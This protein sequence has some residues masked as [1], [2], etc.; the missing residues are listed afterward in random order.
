MDPQI[1]L[2]D[3]HPWFIAILIFY[4]DKDVFIINN[5]SGLL[6]AGK[7]GCNKGLCFLWEISFFNFG[8]IFIFDKIH[9]DGILV[10]IS[11]QT[12]RNLLFIFDIHIIDI[13]PESYQVK[14]KFSNS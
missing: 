8:E 11:I 2:M 13:L 6:F 12:V 5:P 14:F 4:R 9:I 3:N 10:L 1:E 7:I